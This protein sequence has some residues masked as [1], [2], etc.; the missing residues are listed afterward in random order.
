M[1]F[2]SRSDP[3]A[4]GRPA[5]SWRISDQNGVPRGFSDYRGRYV[6]LFFYSGTAT[7][8]CT[9]EARGFRDIHGVLEAA[10]VAL[11]GCGIDSARAHRKWAESEGLAYPILADHQGQVAHAFQVY[12]RLGPFSRAKR[13][14]FVIDPGGRVAHVIKKLAPEQHPEAALTWL[15][16]QGIV[17]AG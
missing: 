8:G 11:L 4:V 9:R 3:L 16:E 1:A 13:V 14:T 6:I 7:P 12:R 15:R 17:G 10:G 2:L 5:P